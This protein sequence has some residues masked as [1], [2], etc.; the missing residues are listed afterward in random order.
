M[1]KHVL[2]GT[3]PRPNNLSATVKKRLKDLR[4]DEPILVTRPSMPTLEDYTELLKGV[5]S[6]RWLTNEGELHQRLE[7]E[8]RSFLDVE[9]LSLFCNGATALLVALQALRINSG[10]VITTPF[11]FPATAHVLHWNHARPVFCDIDPA[12]LN[13]D[14]NAIE[15]LISPET[16]AILAV[17]VYGTPCDVDALRQIG[18]RHGVRIIYDAAHAFDVRLH[19]KSLLEH[20]DVSMLSFHATKVFSTMEGGALVCHSDAER[21]R[22]NSLRNFGIAGEDQIIGPGINGKM[23]ELQAA[24]G[25]LQ[26]ETVRDAIARRQK[27]AM[28]YRRRLKKIDGLRFFEDVP[29]VTHNYGYFPVLVQKSYGLDRD[30]LYMML[31]ECNIF[32]RK[33][34]YPLVTH[35]PTYA[36]LASAA[37]AKLPVAEDAARRVLCLPIYADLR[38][39]Q[40][41]HLCDILSQLPSLA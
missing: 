29:A 41:E 12:T 13:I 6:R 22:I 16:R 25:L 17:H 20:G 7:R 28:T 32:A 11:T 21:Q 24:F 5:W 10:E 38:V 33:Y 14:A 34:F 8:L 27:I 26:L 30:T 2:P 19:G 40:A 23:N 31:R 18:E 39:E 4:V 1:P 3:E 15:R 36:G 37:P 9:H 35:A